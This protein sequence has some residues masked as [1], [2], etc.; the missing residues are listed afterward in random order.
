MAKLIWL[1]DVL[2]NAGQKVEEVPGWTSRG[3]DMGEIKGVLL[4]HTAGSKS[5]NMP[6]LNVIKE[7]RPGLRGPLSQLALGRDGTW[8]VV[9]AGKSNHAGRGSWKNLTKGNYHLIGVEA[10]NTGVENDPWPQV[11]IDAYAE[12]VGAILDFL[13]LP[14][15]CAIGHKE[16]APRRKIDPSFDMNVFREKVGEVMA[17]KKK[18]IK[19]V[20]DY[21]YVP[22][23]A[24]EI[25]E[26][27][28]FEDIQPMP[29]KRK[30]S[31]TPRGILES[32]DWENHQAAAMLAQAIVETNMD[33]EA[34]VYTIDKQVTAKENPN[35]KLHSFGIMKWSG[36]RLDNLNKF[37]DR[38]NHDNK[39]NLKINDKE[40]QIR[41]VDWELRNSEK[42]VYKKLKESDNIMDSLRAAIGYIRPIG[43]SEES[44]ENG[45][46]WA[47][48][49]NAAY[50]L[51]ND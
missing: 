9:A 35:S 5:G 1:S 4:H 25:M 46:G 29:A 50:K 39:T 23:P 34:S 41:F 30:I 20:I 49:V 38:W 24:D 16:W 21:F 15:Y 11:Q 47:N 7:G 14:A 45:A 42:P 44:P 40:L 43:W 36:G 18:S 6:S 17:R 26:E 51:M 22:E 10:E 8:Y 32:L 12:G 27:P 2:R 13:N 19:K 33:P 31:T 48:R 37:V 28:V 3:S